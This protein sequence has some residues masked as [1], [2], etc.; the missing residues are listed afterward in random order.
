MIVSKPKPSTLFSLGAFL[1]AAYG[2]FIYTLIDFIHSDQKALFQYLIMFIIGPI[3][4]G[5]TIKILLS[6]KIIKIGK[7]KIEI[8]YP[9]RFKVYQFKL[10]QIE[11]WKEVIIK[12]GTKFFK[13]LTLTF[14]N[15]Y[16]I[17]LTKQENSSYDEIYGYL[18]KKCPRK[19]A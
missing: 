11:S 6:Y 9:F 14:E 18:K 8:S 7:E 1:F 13:E 16:K 15:K 10:K 17:K 2:L 19:K 4:L 3:A 5:V 12:T